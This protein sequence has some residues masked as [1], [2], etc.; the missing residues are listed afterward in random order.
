MSGSLTNNHYEISLLSGSVTD[1]RG[2]GLDGEWT[3]GTSTFPSGNGLAGGNFDFYIDVLPG[4]AARMAPSTPPSSNDVKAEV[5]VRS[6]QAGYSPYYDLSGGGTINAA[7]S[8]DVKA[9][10]NAR[11][12]TS[13]TPPALTTAGGSGSGGADLTELGLGLQES[14]QATDS[15]VSDFDLAEFWV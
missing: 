4:N 12:S 10:I 2:A 13:S 5:N 6:T 8:N 11:L 9:N 15:A 3:T 14:N 1:S 7:S